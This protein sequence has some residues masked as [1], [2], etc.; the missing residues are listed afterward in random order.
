MCIPQQ[1]PAIPGNPFSSFKFNGKCGLRYEIGVDILVGNIVWVNGPFAAGKYPDVEIFRLGLVHWL[2]EFE[3]VEADDGY[4][5]EAPQR[6]K[7]P[8]CASNPTENEAM[9]NR[10]RSRHESLNGRF[11]NW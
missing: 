4:I 8:G 11:K 6:I 3:R 7:C 1:G 9:Q 2:D 10:V 5:G